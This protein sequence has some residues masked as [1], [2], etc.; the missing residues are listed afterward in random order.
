MRKNKLTE[1]FNPS[2][3]WDFKD[4]LDDYGMEY[5]QEK[6]LDIA[7]TPMEDLIEFF[8]SPLEAIR[9]AFYG[10][11]YCCENDPFN[12]NDDYFC[13]NGYGNLESIPYLDDYLR[14]M[15]D[16]KLFY[17]WCIKQG[18]FEPDEEDDEY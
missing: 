14:D 11:R 18:Y 9:S 4:M 2:E 1:G 5:L 8:D 15:I 6:D 3:D 16:E 7:P 13:F 12:P 10:G 17:K